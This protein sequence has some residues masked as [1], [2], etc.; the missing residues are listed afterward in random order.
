MKEVR[1]VLMREMYGDYD[2]PNF[3]LLEGISDWEQISDEDYCLL[4]QNWAALCHHMDMYNTRI[5]LL[6]KDAVP[7]RKRIDSIKNWIEQERARK[8]RE[9]ELKQ[10]KARQ[11]ALKKL[12]TDAEHERKLLEELKKKYPDN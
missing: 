2:D 10:E 1:I 3:V 4:K 5:I 12:A 6:E 7:V 11:R 8:Q 9:T